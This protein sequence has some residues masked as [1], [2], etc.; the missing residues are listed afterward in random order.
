M[1][2]AKANI[3]QSIVSMQCG[4]SNVLYYATATRIIYFDFDLKKK[5]FEFQV[6]K[7]F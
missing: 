7:L 4:M 6:L 5:N 1:Y 3:S 2:V